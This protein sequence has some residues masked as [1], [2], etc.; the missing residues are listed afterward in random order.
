ML[1]EKLPLTVFFFFFKSGT[2]IVCLQHIM[3]EGPLFLFDILTSPLPSF[4]LQ[5]PARRKGEDVIGL[6]CSVALGAVTFPSGLYAF[7]SLA[8][9]SSE[10]H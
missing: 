7:T 10:T 1:K 4:Y 9:L 6:A 2:S 3:P 8:V 5:Q